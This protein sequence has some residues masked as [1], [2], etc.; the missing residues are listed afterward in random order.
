MLELVININKNKLSSRIVVCNNRIK[1]V[2]F[3]HF[4][5]EIRGWGTGIGNVVKGDVLCGQTK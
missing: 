5:E 3:L 4:G 1:I 2:R